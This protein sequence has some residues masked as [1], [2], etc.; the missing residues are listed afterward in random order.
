M[1]KSPQDHNKSDIMLQVLEYWGLPF[2]AISVISNRETVI[3][4]DTKGQLEWYDL[5]FTAGNY[6]NGR[7]E[8]PGLK[9]RLEYNPG[10]VVF[11]N[12]KVLRHGVSPVNG[13]RV[14]LAGYMRSNIASRFNSTDSA[15]SSRDN[16][17][18]GVGVIQEESNV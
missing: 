1:A 6:S 3:H 15:W 10:T 14:C 2:S 11:L 18:E 5:L 16:F 12:G 8:L 9:L 17:L 13:D 4:R 7:M